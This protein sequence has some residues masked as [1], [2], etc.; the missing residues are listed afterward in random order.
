MLLNLLSRDITSEFRSVMVEGI[1]WML[2]VRDPA[3]ANSKADIFVCVSY[4]WGRGR[5]LNPFVED[6]SVSSRTLPALCAVSR[7]R[8]DCRR[9]W[10]D[11]FCIPGGDDP[12]ERASTLESM[13]FIYS[14]ATEVIVVLSYDSQ[15]VL[16]QIIAKAHLLPK[17]L[18]I[19]EN[20]EWVTRAWTYQEAV[21]S[22][23]LYLTCED[24]ELGVIVEYTQFFSALG[25]A[26]CHLKQDERGRYP[27][28]NAL[29]DLLADCMT[30]IYLQ[31]SALQVMAI[32]DQRTQTRA[33]DH[34][35][36]MIGAITTE[37]ASS[38]G[39]KSPCEAFMSLCEEKGDYSFIYSTARRDQA[40]G[41]RW[42]PVDG[43]DLPAILR[44]HSWGGGQPGHISDGKLYLDE[45]M[46]ILPGRVG[47]YIDVFVQDWL[48]SCNPERSSVPDRER[49]VYLTLKDLGF[50]GSEKY[51]ETPRGYFFPLDP[52]PTEQ[53]VSILV[54]TIIRWKLGAPGI[55]KY[56]GAR[57][58]ACQYVPGVFFGKVPKERGIS[59]DM[60][61]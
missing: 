47:H 49:A 13:G 12:L 2:E 11:A 29:D 37:P 39:L 1:R 53:I 36:A 43:E 10:I 4:T 14:Q 55:V 3:E 23:V 19:L 8:P 34:F 38:V 57:D 52:I 60:T 17:H 9:I 21:N 54:S 59:S 22:Q 18:D 28:L 44:H 31:R 7:Q 33:E 48:S 5:V 42:R 6:I 27:R 26:L 40:A 45:M 25:Q 35:Y 16:Q 20:E 56:R 51:I 50:A 30:A 61:R 24:G 15:P 32:M 46:E 58:G 41:R